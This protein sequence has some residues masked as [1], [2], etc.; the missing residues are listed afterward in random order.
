MKTSARRTLLASAIAVA[1][2]ARAQPADA[3]LPV[4]PVEDLGRLAATAKMIADAVRVTT[5]ISGALTHIQNAAIGLGGGNLVDDILIGHRNLTDDLHSISYSIE[6]ISTQFGAVFP[7]REAA[8]HVSP[9]D[10]AQLRN[11]WDQ[12]LHQSALAASRAQSSLSRMEDNSRSAVTILER[13]KATAGSDGEGSR[14]AKLQALVQMLG[15]VNSDLTTLGTTIATTER[16]NADAAAADVSDES[17]EAARAERMMRDYAKEEPI[18][19]VQLDI[20]H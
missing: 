13:S 2:C 11:N 17:L 16:V 14:L 18:P 8:S 10:A 15:V 1:L 6:T 7:T 19:D 5:Q 9:S 3:F 4:I 12:E 20:L